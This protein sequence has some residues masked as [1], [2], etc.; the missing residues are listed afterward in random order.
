MPRGPRLRSAADIYHVTA[1]GAGRQLIFE[2]D[3]DRE[4]FIN[5]LRGQLTK[6]DGKALAWCLMSNH[7]HLLLNIDM[8][9]LAR[10]MRNTESSYA[11]YFNTRHEHVGHLFQDRFGSEPVNDDAHLVTVI[12]YIHTNPARAGICAASEYRWSSYSE[13][14]GGSRN[15]AVCDMETVR[16]LLGDPQRLTTDATVPASAPDVPL[17]LDGGR[18]TVLDDD[19]AL[20][21]AGQIVGDERL[22]NLKA[23]PRGERD[24][25]LERLLRH[26]FTIRQ[27][28]RLTGVGRGIIQ[29][30][31]KRT[32][33]G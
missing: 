10:V 11:R 24:D 32:L 15:P 16:A 18:V 9:R 27:L 28:E 3:D 12:L 26:G 33:G 6:H 20:Y 19:E 21:V 8:D 22:R 5:L 17:L 4:C 23:L 25:T 30:L 2:D 29:H 14:A 1:R 31:R 7:V 13:Y